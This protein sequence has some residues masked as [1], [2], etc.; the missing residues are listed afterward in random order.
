MIESRR[1]RLAGHMI[2]K[3]TERNGYRI[4][5]GKRK[6]RRPLRNISIKNGSREID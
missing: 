3:E 5:M 6:G 4:S 2:R 1:M